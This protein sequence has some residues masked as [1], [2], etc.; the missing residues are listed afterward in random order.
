MVNRYIKKDKSI[1]LI[2]YIETAM[3]M[4]S[5]PDLCRSALDLSKNS[6]FTLSTLIFG[7]DDFCANIGNDLH[8]NIVNTT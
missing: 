8:I 5:L 1:N 3:A 2:M 6:K 7:S 4:I